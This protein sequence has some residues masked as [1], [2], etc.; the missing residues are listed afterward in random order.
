M[1]SHRLARWAAWSL[2]V[3]SALLPG[4]ARVVGAQSSRDSTA[5]DSTKARLERLEAELVLLRR[6]VGEEFSTAVRTRSRLT[7]TLHARIQTN[8]FATSGRTNSVDVPTFVLAPAARAARPGSPGTRALGLSA[9]QSRVGASASLDSV[10]GGVFEGDLDLD[11]SGGPAEAPG[12]RRLFPEPRLRTAR[13]RLV[14]ERTELLVGAETPLISDLNPVSLAAVSVTGFVSAGNLW[15]WLPQVRVSRDL[16]VLPGGARVGLQ[17]AVLAPFTGSQNVSESDAVDAGERAARPFLQTRVR[18]QWGNASAA[19]YGDGE[20]RAAGGEIGIGAHRGWLRTS[21]TRLE[22]SR[23]ISGDLLVALLR[24]V[25][26][27]GEVY[28]GQLL[29]GLGGGA[30][31]QNFGLAADGTTTGSPLQD[32]A[33]WF[34]LN[35]QAHPSVVTGVGCGFNRVEPAGRPVR[36]FNN[37]CSA[38]ALVRP[39]LPLFVGLEY[40]RLATRYIDRVYRASH[41]N[42]VLG[43]EL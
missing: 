41:L 23:A 11:F 1:R 17:G 40:R 36:D 29:R 20:V 2:L 39:A 38:H 8:L 10:L 15:N 28:A 24:A 16:A 31:G 43:F 37:S 26:L 6:Q 19:A 21:G 34:Q 27:R 25:E 32:V 14:W 13:A 7:L 30:I 33:G 3:G 35:A 22:T 18:L 5:A 4:S 12:D 42:L 9:R